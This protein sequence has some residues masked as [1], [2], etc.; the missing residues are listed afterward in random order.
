MFNTLLNSFNA[1]GDLS[2]QIVWMMNFTGSRRAVGTRPATD[3]CQT[4]DL[5]VASSIPVWS[6]TFC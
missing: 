3:A 5:G 4:A 2:L 6:L 1:S